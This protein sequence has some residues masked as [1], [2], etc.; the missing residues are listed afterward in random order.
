MKVEFHDLNC[1]NELKYVVI[2]AKYKGQWIFVR[3]KDRETWEI[4]GGHIEN[5]ELADKAAEREL[6][7]ETGALEFY[8]K[9][10]CNYSVSR[11]D[12]KS[13]G[14]LYFAEVNK[15]GNLAQFEIAEII[16]RDE[17]PNNL[18]YE[19]IQPYLFKKVIDF[20]V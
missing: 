8:L 17:L 6:K 16:F 14:R 5:D 2:Q 19:K 4:P 13:Y 7:E 18:T 11:G 20:L 12:K 3:H 10:I 1:I 9:P 15:L